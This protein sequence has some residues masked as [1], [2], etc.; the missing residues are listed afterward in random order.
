MIEKYN[1]AVI[2]KIKIFRLKMTLT[3]KILLSLLFLNITFKSQAQPSTNKLQTLLQIDF[4]RKINSLA[5]SFTSEVYNDKSYV[6][7]YCSSSDEEFKVKNC[8]VV[9]VNFNASSVTRNQTCQTGFH[10][11]NNGGVLRSLFVHQQR[12][13]TIVLPYLHVINSDEV[14]FKF[15]MLRV[16]TCK[17]NDVKLPVDSRILTQ[18]TIL[19]QIL[20]YDDASFELFVPNDN[21]SCAAEAARCKLSFDSNGEKIGEPVGYLSSDLADR[22]VFFVHG[23][24]SKTYYAFVGVSLPML[25]TNEPE[26]KN[27]RLFYVNETQSIMLLAFDFNYRQ[28][29]DDSHGHFG[30]CFSSSNDTRVFCVNCTQYDKDKRI[31]D[32]SFVLADSLPIATYNVPDGGIL[33]V[34]GKCDDLYCENL[35]FHEITLNGSVQ[36]RYKDEFEYLKPS[37]TDV[38]DGDD[39]N[40]LCLTMYSSGSSLL[41]TK[42]CYPRNWLVCTA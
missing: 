39:E 23:P 1:L 6:E 2:R 25:N 24:T 29:I 15:R 21:K 17:F 36:F 22:A 42:K 20:I 12:N 18:P 33:F 35:I 7:A 5:A 13:D 10:T 9:L 32:V 26:D 3:S 40:Q 8:E 4:P 16:S 14:Y 28:F 11:D 38:S 31:V 41:L 30:F 34:S 19:P 37:L 27:S